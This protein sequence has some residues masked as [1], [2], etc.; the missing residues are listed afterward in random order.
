MKA[1][2]IFP[3]VDESGTVIGQATRS[4]CHSGS[5]ILH[6]V[7][8]LH[9]FNSDGD[10]YLQKRSAKKDIQPNRWDSSVGGHIDVNEAPE[11]AAYREAREEL[12]IEDIDISYITKYIIET[13]IEKEL[14]Y[15]FYTIYDGNFKIDNDEVADG[16]FWTIH[17]IKN[18]LGKDIFTFNFEC[19]FERFLQNGLHN[20]DVKIK[21]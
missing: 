20:I 7:I 5:K 11:E 13:A 4:E 18:N 10:L 21:E 9:V 1:E 17:E 12:G 19:D 2:E 3:I 15:C 16:R 8:H 6:P 14:T